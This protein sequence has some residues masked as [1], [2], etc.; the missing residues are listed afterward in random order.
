MNPQHNAIIGAL[1]SKP[2]VLPSGSKKNPSV[3]RCPVRSHPSTHRHASVKGHQKPYPPAPRPAS[4][5]LKV[6]NS[7]LKIA[8]STLVTKISPPTFKGQQNKLAQ[9]TAFPIA[10]LDPSLPTVT[11]QK[12]G[13]LPMK[14]REQMKQSLLKIQQ[15]EGKIPPSSF[16]PASAIRSEK[17][18]GAIPKTFPL[19]SL[20]TV[21][22]ED[23]SK[24]VVNACKE[25][26]Q[27]RLTTLHYSEEQLALRKRSQDSD[28]FGQD[29][30]GH[31]ENELPVSRKIAKI[32]RRIFPRQE[33]EGQQEDDG[34]NGVSTII[35]EVDVGGLD[36]SGASSLGSLIPDSRSK[37][38]KTELSQLREDECKE[39]RRKGLE[40]LLY[41]D[42]RITRSQNRSLPFAIVY[43]S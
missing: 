3:N 43:N 24:I 39:L 5:N 2:F 41:S 25:P 26:K 32:D 35:I 18:E 31:V 12:L 4:A 19:S 13:K 40:E 1:P 9:P 21:S 20:P 7:P 22:N 8:G 28:H 15:Q 11:S 6:N 10:R 33:C 17:I 14:K 38:K 42:Q 29:D 23:V 37:Q 16:S 34:S 36:E 30:D 27:K